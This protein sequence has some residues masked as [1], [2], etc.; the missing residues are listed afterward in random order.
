MILNERKK[1]TKQ[2]PRRG[3]G[4]VPPIARLRLPRA[5]GRGRELWQYTR[6]NRA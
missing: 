5:A 2:R 1:I 3:A 6:S 4:I